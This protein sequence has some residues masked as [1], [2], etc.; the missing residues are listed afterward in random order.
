MN[1]T[2]IRSENMRLCLYIYHL[3]SLLILVE[4]KPVLGKFFLLLIQHKQF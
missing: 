1:K 2:I 4:V 3:D